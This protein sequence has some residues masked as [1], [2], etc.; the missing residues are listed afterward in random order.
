MNAL[1]SKDVALRG[2]AEQLREAMAGIL[3]Q[4]INGDSPSDEE[5]VARFPQLMPESGDAL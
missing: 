4:R 3:Q 5:L 1:S 2:R